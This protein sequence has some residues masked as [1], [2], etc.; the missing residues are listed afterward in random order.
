MMFGCVAICLFIATNLFMHL[1]H[2]EHLFFEF[3]DI[4]VSMAACGLVV[5]GMILFMTLKW[6]EKTWTRLG[7][8]AA[9]F[10][11]E[12]K[13]GLKDHSHLEEE[14][15]NAFLDFYSMAVHFYVSHNLPDSF[16]YELFIHETLGQNICDLININWI[17]WVVLLMLSI[18]GWVLAE[19]LE[20]TIDTQQATLIFTLFCAAS[21]APLMCLWIDLKVRYKKLCKRL[22]TGDGA[23]II[24]AA[25]ELMER[26]IQEDLS[27]GVDLEATR[28]SHVRSFT[29]DLSTQMTKTSKEQVANGDAGAEDWEKEDASGYAS[30]L[31]IKK[32]AIQTL[33]LT[34][35]FELSLY[36]MH[37]A[38]NISNDHLS[39]AWHIIIVALII[40]QMF[41]LPFIL[42]NMSLLEA[43]CCPSSSILDEVI[44]ASKQFERDCDFIKSQLENLATR[45][46]MM[47]QAKKAHKQGKADFR[48]MLNHVG[49]FM[50]TNTRR[51]VSMTRA[52]DDFRNALSH[53]GISVSSRRLAR[54]TPFMDR[55]GNGSLSVTEFLEGV[56]LDAGYLDKL[57]LQ[58]T[59]P[60][61]SLVADLPSLLQNTSDDI[62][63]VPESLKEQI[64][65][66]HWE[67]PEASI[68]PG[69][70]ARLTSFM[71]RDGNMIV[72][73]SKFHESLELKC[74]TS[75]K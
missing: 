14:F 8:R 70:L 20:A 47:Q 44:D 26:K 73:L 72:Q 4:M 51:F 52:H 53:F 13:S 40:L 21:C 54:L 74:A 1:S 75:F 67:L 41:L 29:A 9:N 68:S 49:F 63:K 7:L 33:G 30:G 50:T 65:V 59:T 58:P 34:S 48:H 62:K 66:L 5:V 17:T 55:D 18:I 71:D 56:G 64:D 12:L 36:L 25:K 22:R 45:P 39:P 43:Y 35:C 19:T 32:Q 2:E 6:L 60:A 15:S 11:Q 37:F 31:G 3:T 23:Q 69:G 10:H 16:R 57:G 61:I 42:K 28:Q 24:Q 27:N 38:Y 46:R